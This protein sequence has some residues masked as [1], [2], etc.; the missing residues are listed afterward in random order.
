[1]LVSLSNDS[2]S[3][4]STYDESDEDISGDLTG[5][6]AVFFLYVEFSLDSLRTLEEALLILLG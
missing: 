2:D 6:F 4:S 1:M 3:C 5:D